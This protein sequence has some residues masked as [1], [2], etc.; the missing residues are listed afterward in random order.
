MWEKSLTP[1]WLFNGSDFEGIW[2]APHIF[3]VVI[4]TKYHFF[5]PLGAK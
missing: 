2:E 1:A 5:P 4:F 3:F